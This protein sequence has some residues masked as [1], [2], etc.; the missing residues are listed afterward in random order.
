[1]NACVAGS[2]KYKTRQYCQNMT[3]P[4]IHSSEEAQSFRQN[5]RLTD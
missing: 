4:E 3:L 5:Y 2:D 1:M